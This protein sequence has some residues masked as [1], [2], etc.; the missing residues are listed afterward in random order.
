MQKF[1][2]AWIFCILAS[3]IQIFSINTK[4]KKKFSINAKKVWIY[5]KKF[6]F[7]QNFWYK[8][9]KTQKKCGPQL[10][11]QTQKIEHLWLYGNA[12]PNFIS[13]IIDTK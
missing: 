3:Q 7:I 2:L 10:F 8:L 12:V 4:N 5:T 1:G 9:K 11:G 13:D 6:M